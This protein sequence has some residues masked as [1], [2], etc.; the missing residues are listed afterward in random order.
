MQ[1]SFYS[2]TS[3]WHLTLILSPQQQLHKGTV[4]PSE[5][6]YIQRHCCLSNI[7]NTIHKKK[8]KLTSQHIRA[9]IKDGGSVKTFDF[10]DVG[11]FWHMMWK[12]QVISVA[13]VTGHSFTDQPPLSSL[14]GTYRFFS[15]PSSPLF[16]WTQWKWQYV[17]CLFF[18]LL[19]SVFKVNKS[20]TNTD[21]FFII[22]C[23]L[24]TNKWYSVLCS[25]TL[26]TPQCFTGKPPSWDLWVDIIFL[27]ISQLFWMQCNLNHI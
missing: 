16:S 19:F 15:W 4:T 21:N 25:Y 2:D 7:H 17:S 13:K 20:N 26:H 6:T 12:D 10:K 3:L 27:I 8:Q 9:P 18:F 22:K 23:V 24:A 14:S 5:Q 11:V 1:T